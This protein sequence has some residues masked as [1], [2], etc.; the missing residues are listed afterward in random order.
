MKEQELQ[1]LF[2]S[3]SLK[4][5]AGQLFQLA[6]GMLADDTAMMGPMQDMGIEKED[7]QLAGTV[8]GSMG[9]EKIREIQDAYMENHPHHIPLIFML[10]IINGYKTIYPIPLAQGAAFSPKLTEACAAMAAREGAAA[11]LHVT[12]SP[13]VDLVRDPRWGRVMESTGEDVYLNGCMAEAMVKGYQGADLKGAETLAACVKHF[14]GYGGAEAGRDYNTVE[15][16]ERSFRDF[17]LPAYQKAIDAGSALVMTSFNTINGIPATVNRWLMRSVLREEM[18]FDGVL[19]SDFGAIGETVCHGVAE[20]R[21]DAARKGI[22]A[23]CDIDMMSGTY[24]ENLEQLIEDG[25]LDIKLVEESAWRVLQLKNRL[26]L[27]ENPYKGADQGKEREV[28]LCREHQELARKMAQESFVLLKNE[29]ELLPLKKERKT[30]FIGPYVENKY[31]LGGWSFTGDPQDAR[32]IRE[33]CGELKGY[34]ITFHKGCPVLSSDVKLEGFGNYTQETVPAKQQEEMLSQAIE[35]AKAADE[36]VLFLGEHFLQSGEATSHG[37]IMIPRVQQELLDRIYEVNPEIAVVLFNGRPLDLRLVQKKAKAILEVW[38]PGTMGGAA[39]VDTLTGK[40]VPGGKVPMS[41]PY[42]VGQI[43][44]HYD[45]LPTGRTHLPGKDKDRFV[46]KYLDI[47]NK[48]SYPFGYG[49][50]Y[51]RFEISPVQLSGK[52]LHAGEHIEAEVVVK[53]IGDRAGTETVQLYLH[54]VSASVSRPVKQLKGFQKIVL[55]P[56]Q[57][58]VVRF[59]ITESMLTFLREDDTVGSEPGSFEVYIGSDSET[60]NKAVFELI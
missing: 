3:M 22:E 52:T 35:A 25:R 47:P 13:M 7:I 32:T 41:F 23:G 49:L 59:S 57:E 1:Q 20:N 37:E 58:T 28:C 40:A 16:S 8:L 38:M 27:F 36:V 54:D 11:G 2:D 12:F 53:N 51:T 15:V 50:S 10:D 60:K 9:A 48:P 19:I 24:P 34:D 43:P 55:E 21:S 17:Y 4:E 18:K 56:Q 44:V 31:M 42:S 33:A 39:I 5:K 30:A 29:E 26:G 14:A 6:G 45:E 46:S